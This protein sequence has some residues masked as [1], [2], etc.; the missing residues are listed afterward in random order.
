MTDASVAAPAPEKFG[1]LTPAF[2]GGRMLVGYVAMVFGLFMAIL[3]IQIVSSSLAEI[4]AGLSAT[5]DEISWVQSSYLIAE[6]IMIP[7]SGYLSRLLSTRI[8]FCISC[9]CFTAAS[10]ACAFADSIE[11]MIVFRAL[12][13][14]LGGA[15]IPTVFAASFILFPGERRARASVIVGLVATLAP[16]VGPTLGGWIT[17]WLSWHWLFLINVLPGI[18]VSIAV[19]CFADLDRPDWSLL[20]NID[21]AGLLGMALFLGSLEYVL[22]EGPRHD[23]LEE[24]AIRNFAFVALFGGLLFFW[25]AFTAKNPIVE[26]HAFKDRNFAIGSIFGLALGVGLYGLVYILPLYLAQ[27]RQLNAGQIGEIMFVTGLC[28]F[29]AAPI[30]GRLSQSID[31]RLILT[32]GFAGLGIST[33]MLADLTGEW[34]FDQLLVPQ[35]IRG[36]ALMMCIVPLNV[37]ALGTLPPERLKGAAGLYNLMRNLGGAFGLAGINTVLAEARAEHWSTLV[38]HVNPGLPHV[39][40]LLDRLAL[41]LGDLLP[42]DAELMALARVTAMVRQQA[43]V[44]G[45][46][47]TFFVLGLVFLLVAAGVCTVKKPNTGPAAAHR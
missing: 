36:A 46:A 37:L 30:V 2:G 15:M 11:S 25:R 42:G 39:Q 14:F 22:E 44:L 8:L 31:P 23:W 10:V 21:I 16:T 27:V 13:G 1:V 35:M 7:L 20:K 24:P 4:Q 38:P 29:I 3:D 40:A 6:V 43:L 18:L 28:Q 12:Q 34:G 32:A 5:A 26:L 47:D 41:R 33:L 17:Q 19:W 45:F 9:A